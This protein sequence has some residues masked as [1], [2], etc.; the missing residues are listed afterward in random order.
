MK[1]RGTIEEVIVENVGRA[2]RIA[3]CLS[4]TQLVRYQVNIAELVA[5][6]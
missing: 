3:L 4:R 2:L 6:G 1:I 5:S